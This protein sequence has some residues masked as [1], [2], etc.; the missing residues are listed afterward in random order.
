M[1][2]LSGLCR[3]IKTNRFFPLLMETLVR[4]V[5]SNLGAESRGQ[6]DFSNG[7]NEDSLARGPEFKALGDPAGQNAHWRA[8]DASSRVTGLTGLLGSRK[9]GYKQFSNTTPSHRDEH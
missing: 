8:D 3:D 1:R 9:E 2:V 6:T 5:V 7:S 4:R